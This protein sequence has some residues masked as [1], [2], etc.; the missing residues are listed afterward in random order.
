MSFYEN[1]C[2]VHIQ[3]EGF[4]NGYFVKIQSEDD[5]V[6]YHIEKDDLISILQRLHD[7]V[8]SKGVVS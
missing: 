4:H 3:T 7:A 8:I 5:T 2:D 1:V 6:V